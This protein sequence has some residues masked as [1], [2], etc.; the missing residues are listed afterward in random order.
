MAPEKIPTN[1]MSIHKQTS[2]ASK[3]SR[4]SHLRTGSEGSQMSLPNN[5]N[6]A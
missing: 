3:V 6:N 1:Q 2:Y 4:K 5:S